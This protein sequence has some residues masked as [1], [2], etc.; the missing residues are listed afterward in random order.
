MEKSTFWGFRGL[1]VHRVI[2]KKHAAKETKQAG[3]KVSEGEIIRRA[4]EE[5]DSN[6]SR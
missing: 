3:K 4:I 2:V 5:Y 6:H 1:K